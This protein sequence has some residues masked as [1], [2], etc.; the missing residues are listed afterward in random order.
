[1]KIDQWPIVVYPVMRIG[2]RSET[3]VRPRL[4]LSTSA[5]PA[6]TIRLRATDQVGMRA[7]L[8]VPHSLDCLAA[9]Q[10]GVFTRPQVLRY[11]GTQPLINRM[12]R[13][14]SWIRIAQGVYT[15]EPGVSFDALCHAGLLLAG[16]GSIIG[17]LASGHLY[18]VVPPPP[19]ITVWGDRSRTLGPWQFRRSGLLDGVGSPLRLRAED[20]LLDSCGESPPGEVL[21]LLI[22][23]LRRQVSTPARLR[24]RA[25]ERGSLRHRRLVLSLLPD[26]E[27]GVE[28]TLEHQFLHRVQ[29]A[30][31]LPEG[32]RQVS[33]S[34]G[35]RSDV[36]IHDYGVVIELDGRRGHEGDDKWRDYERDNRHLVQGLATL[37]F[38][39]HDVVLRPC[40]VAA[41]VADVIAQHGWPGVRGGG[42]LRRCGSRCTA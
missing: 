29:R 20:A 26:I 42:G 8:D 23:G 31:L 5:I 7:R 14:R 22:R 19:R 34:S 27:K 4:V 24:E 35:T 30:H 36:L 12:L 33:L 11:G 25:E 15:A 32:E 16:P 1:M 18:G 21:D 41:M 2:H 13:T 9:A 10:G 37:R 39:W 28:S 17:G 38:G 40:R 6:R 3:T